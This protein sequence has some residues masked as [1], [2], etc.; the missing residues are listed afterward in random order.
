MLITDI[1][2]LGDSRLN[3]EEGLAKLR[4]EN[5]ALAAQKKIQG[6]DELEDVNR[7][8]GSRMPWKELIFRLTKCNPTLQFRDGTP[9]N[10]AAYIPKNRY[11][12][13]EGDYDP[14][15][16]DFGNDHKY[17]SGFPKDWIPEFSHITV[18]ERGLPKREIRGWRTILISMIQ[19][20]AITYRDAV[21][22]FGEAN[23]QRSNRWHQ[24]LQGKK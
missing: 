13:A 12:L 9:G 8:G 11:E 24:L 17:I 4:E 14:S 21:K 15:R 1:Q 16:S 19:A 23:G 5:L 2:N 22:Q 10:V 6:Q 7:S 3:P 18:D 20:G